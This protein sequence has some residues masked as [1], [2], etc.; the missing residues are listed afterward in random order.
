ELD[1]SMLTGETL[2]QTARAGDAIQAGVINLNQKLIMR[3]GA[4]VEDSSVAALARLVETSAQGRARF[5]R[6]ADRAA[7]LYVPVVHTMAA[8]TFLGWMVGPALLRV[9]G[10]EA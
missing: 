1:R 5:V 7:A 6:L 4:R 2:P 8:L 3:A 9:A 10:F